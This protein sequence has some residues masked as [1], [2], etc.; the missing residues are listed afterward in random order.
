M[1]LASL[2]TFS[3]STPVGQRPRDDELD[4]FGLTHP[5]RV[6]RENQDHF[7]VLRSMTSARQ[8]CETL[9]QDALDGGGSDNITIV[10]GRAMQRES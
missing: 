2:F 3:G 7:L 10:V 1:K 6:R 9:L 4:L 5:G 8:A